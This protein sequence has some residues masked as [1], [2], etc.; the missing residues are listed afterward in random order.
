MAEDD[1]DVLYIGG[2]GRSGST[3]LERLLG[4]LPTAIGSTLES[5]RLPAEERGAISPVLRLDRPS[6][7]QVLRFDNLTERGLCRSRQ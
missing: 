7:G 1:V 2:Y 6:A 4:H 3:L 5:Q